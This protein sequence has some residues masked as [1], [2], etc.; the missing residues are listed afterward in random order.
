[1]ALSEGPRSSTQTHTQKPQVILI[2][3]NPPDL[4]DFLGENGQI[5]VHLLEPGI[6]S[7]AS[8][9]NYS[10]GWTLSTSYLSS[11]KKPWSS[12][13][14]L[15]T[16][17]RTSP[18]TGKIIN[19]HVDV[20]TQCRSSRIEEVVGRQN[21][22]TISHGQTLRLLVRV[23]AECWK[24]AQPDPY[25]NESEK[26]FSELDSMLGIAETKLLHVVLTYKHSLLPNTSPSIVH[27]S[28][29]LARPNPTSQWSCMKTPSHETTQRERHS[30]THVYKQLML[31]LS[32]TYSPKHA[33]QVLDQTFPKSTLSSEL[34]GCLTLLRAELQYQADVVDKFGLN[35]EGDD[36][37]GSTI[38]TSR[39]ASRQH[40][41]FSHHLLLAPEIS[42]DSL[43][44]TTSTSTT[45]HPHPDHLTHTTTSHTFIPTFT[46]T[47]SPAPDEARQIW[48]SIRR[49]SRIQN[50]GSFRRGG[51]RSSGFSASLVCSEAEMSLERIVVAD[52]R[53]KGIREMALR[54]KRSIGADTLRSISLGERGR[55]AMR[56]WL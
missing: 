8:K 4:C 15:I 28:C 42:T 30:Q 34:V 49:D 19:L 44:S 36:E 31:C 52:E 45:V 14:E 51:H 56:G 27:K 12:L 33:I 18:P 37:S 40:T 5:P 21:F 54:S 2:S 13:K 46:P 50:D 24:P 11:L 29:V 41:H 25:I 3:A 20:N 1:M 47:S 48:K 43:P 35:V 23:R 9:P 10:T 17:A 22:G 6:V 53:L 32:S 38:I 7:W 16:Y 55:G 26:L 39:S